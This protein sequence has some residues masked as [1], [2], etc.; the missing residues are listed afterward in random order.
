M[1]EFG[2][3]D[4]ARLVLELILVTLDVARKAPAK[5]DVLIISAV[6]DHIL[7]RGRRRGT[8]ALRRLVLRSLRSGG[9]IKTL[10]RGARCG[11]CG[12]RESGSKRERKKSSANIHGETSL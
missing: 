7:N 10:G 5:D 11:L 9:S 1:I 4:A 3:N 12:E 6:L 2:G 8:K